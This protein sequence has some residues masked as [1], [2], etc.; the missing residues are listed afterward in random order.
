MKDNKHIWTE[1]LPKDMA[2]TY[3]YIYIL[4]NKIYRSKVSN[5]AA[6]LQNPHDMRK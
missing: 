3:I 5:T 2:S 4:R 1:M 6:S